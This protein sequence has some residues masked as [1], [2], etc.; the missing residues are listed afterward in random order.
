[1]VSL[2]TPLILPSVVS[3]PFPEHLCPPDLPATLTVIKVPLT[4]TCQPKT[5]HIQHIILHNF[6][7]PQRD[8]TIKH[9]FLPTGKNSSA[10]HRVLSLCDSLV[11][12]YFPT[13]SFLALTPAGGHCATPAHPPPFW[14]PNTPS[15]VCNTSPTN[16]LGSS[17]VS[18]ALN[19]G[20]FTMLRPVINW[21]T[22]SSSTSAPSATSRA[23]WWP[24]NFNCNSHSCSNVPIRGLLLCHH[25]VTLRVEEQHL[26]FRLGSLQPDNMIFDF[27]LEVFLYPSPLLFLI[28]VSHLYSPV[29]TPLTPLLLIPSSF[30]FSYGPPSP[31]SP[32]P[33]PP[34]WPHLPP[35]CYHLYHPPIFLFLHLP[36]SFLDLKKV[37]A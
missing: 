1:M 13:I 15:R 27:I 14:A 5:L 17:I 25:E 9:I 6:R 30:P 24:N 33:F 36:P 29:L 32:L 22:S 20:A 35:S 26:V 28:L 31:S 34:T 8:P 21:G 37:L 7:H 16:L 2:L 10:F 18:S 12:S 23:S 11:N 19:A 3:P 4:L